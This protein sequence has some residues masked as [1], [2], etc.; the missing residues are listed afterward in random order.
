MAQVVT[1]DENAPDLSK[2]QMLAWTALAGV[3]YLIKTFQMLGQ[4]ITGDNDLSQLPD[5]DTT[6]MALMGI[7]QAAYLGKKAADVETPKDTK[8][9]GEAAKGK[10]GT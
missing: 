2:V 10:A 6:L 9:E 4:Y 3:I 5:I 7:G 8:A 1:D